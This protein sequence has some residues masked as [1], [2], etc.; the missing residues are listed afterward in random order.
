V[1]NRLY[2][3]GLAASFNWAT[4]YNSISAS[5]LA[6]LVTALIALLVPAIRIL[7]IIKIEIETEN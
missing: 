7:E 6:L 2:D 5:A 1:Q 4:T 3:Y